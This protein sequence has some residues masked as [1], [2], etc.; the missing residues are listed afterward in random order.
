M[1]LSGFAARHKHK[2]ANYLTRDQALARLAV[3][4]HKGERH[5]WYLR[6]VELASL[7][8]KLVTGDGLDDLLRQFVQREDDVSFNQRKTLTHHVVTTTVK[9]LMDVTRKVPRANYQRVLQAE[10]AKAAED[11]EAALKS[12]WGSK[13]LDDYI[14]TRWLEVNATDPNA[15]VVVEF[16]PFDN[17]IE[18]A[19]PYPYEVSSV[20]AVDYSMDNNILQHLIVKSEFESGER[21]TVYLKNETF[22]MQQFPKSAQAINL[23]IEDGQYILNENGGWFRSGKKLFVL[24]FT[25]PHN[26]DFVPAKQFGYLRD[27]WTNGHTFVAPFDAAVPLLLKS[28]KVNSEMDLTMA[29]SAFPFRLEYAPKC[30]ALDCFN[31]YT[32]DGAAMCASCKGTGHKSVVSAQEKLV[33]TLPKSADML[34]DLDKLVVFKSPPVDILAFQQQYVDGLTASCKSA[35]FNSDIFTKQQVS[36]TA[37]GKRIDLDNVYDTLFDCALGMGEAWAF[38]VK[39]SANFMELD[40][41]L[42]AEL[43]FAKDFK[44]KGLTDLLEDLESANRSE[45]GPEVKRAIHTD[46][47]RLIFADNAYDFARWE[48][49]S[50]INPF[51]GYSESHVALALSDPAVPQRY[52]TLY[53]MLGAIFDELEADSL[54][55]GRDFYMVA[56]AE[57]RKLVNE[58]VSSYMAETALRPNLPVNMN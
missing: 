5:P 35:M 12:F 46:L 14:K 28:I 49:K 7:Y 30:D 31:G 33:L 50:R 48:A 16:K 2:N 23:Q 8:R 6:T 13:S 18:R 32:N 26:A 51:A 38:L 41:D 56:P 29:L 25:I 11:L 44:L 37:T 54:A 20:A 4:V 24:T 43:I 9:N 17:N 19:K 53:L 39:T 22:V 34:F 42:R 52:K 15:F 36:D 27:S 47:A 58:K 3:V 10:N 21:Y 55:A 57:Q 45:A 1:I 40:K